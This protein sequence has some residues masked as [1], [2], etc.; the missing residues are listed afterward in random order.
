MIR[1]FLLA[2]LLS[3]FA[4]CDGLTIG[5]DP[6]P[7]V[8]TP[9]VQ[10]I[11][12]ENPRP[13]VFPEKPCP[14]GTCPNGQCPNAQS[15]D[16]EGWPAEL[17]PCD[18]SANP[19]RSVPPMDLPTAFRQSNYAGGSCMY[20]A[21]I[22]VLRWQERYADADKMRQSYSGAEGVDGMV[23]VCSAMRLRFAYT[24][25]GD[26]A[27]LDWCSRTRRGAAIHYWPN[28]AVT[29]C[30]YDADGK[31]VLLDNNAV[32][33]YTR[34]PRAQFLMAWRG[35]GG[36]ALTVVYTPWPPHPWVPKVRA[37]VASNTFPGGEP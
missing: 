33:R 24:A 19:Y 32:G 17:M 16:L 20:A 4:G 6:T 12:P 25:Q 14:D 3:L 22:S 34:I 30:G 21:L 10:P 27:F 5:E 8:P 2:C 36:R 23:G 11:T 9:I 26:T 31:A 13:F 29:F 7:A 28:H 1:V 35:Y 15:A 37:I 18:E